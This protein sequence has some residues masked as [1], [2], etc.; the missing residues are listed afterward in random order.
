MKKIL[1]ALLFFIVFPLSASHIVGGEFE[2]LYLKKNSY[3][4]QLIYY[5]DVNNGFP[6]IKLPP[7]DVEPEIIVAIYRK[8][9]NELMDIHTLKFEE[10]FRVSYMQ[11]DCSKGEVVTDK[12][13]YSKIITLSDEKYGDAEGYYVIWERC[14][15]NYSIENIFSNPPD[16]N[17]NNPFSA[18]QTFYLQFP[19]VVMDGKE[20]I[21]STPKLFPPLNDYACPNKILLC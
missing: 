11:P 5:F 15:R 2:L 18:G 14:C 20:F 10:K 17:S 12:M 16:G 21:N 8:R 13:I 4:L 9:D 3:K 1:L 19:P 6:G 7:E